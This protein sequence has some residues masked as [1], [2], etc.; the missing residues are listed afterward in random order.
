MLGINLLIILQLRNQ[1][2]NLPFLGFSFLFCSSYSQKLRNRPSLWSGDQFII[3]IILLVHLVLSLTLPLQMGD[4]AHNTRLKSLDEAVKKLQADSV[5]HTNAL[6]SINTVL[7]DIVSQL[8]SMR[9]SSSAP[10]PPTTSPL[11][12]TPGLFST[13]SPHT[14]TQLPNSTP[15]LA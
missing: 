2:R 1:I 11:S 12:S 10:L 5:S 13:P 6:E 4:G 9:P 15:T 14:F 8:A 3:N 7:Q